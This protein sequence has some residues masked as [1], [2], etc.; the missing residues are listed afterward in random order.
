MWILATKLPNSDLNFAVDFWVDF[1]LLFFQGEWPPKI[2]SKIHLESS[3]KIHSDV[4][5]SLVLIFL[6]HE[7]LTKNAPKISPKILSLYFVGPKKSHKIPAK[8]P[9]NVLVKMQ[10]NS[11]T[12]FCRRAG[13]TMSNT[14]T[15]HPPQN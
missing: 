8:V 3:E 7:F 9:Q 2:H 13:R 1:F 11:P 5:I 14:A 4:C 15:S 6:R 10:K 12:S